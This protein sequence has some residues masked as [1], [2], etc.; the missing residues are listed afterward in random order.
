[1]GSVSELS[2]LRARYAWLCQVVGADRQRLEA[3]RALSA[4]VD[5]HPDVCERLERR[6]PAAP[7]PAPRPK[8]AWEQAVED[9]RRKLAY[10]RA[11]IGVPSR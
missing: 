5:A 4:Y 9:A 3:F 7:A 11:A 10:R 2:S 8:S 6:P 1:M